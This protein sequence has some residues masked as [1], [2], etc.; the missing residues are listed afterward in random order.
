MTLSLTDQVFNLPEHNAESFSLIGSE[1]GKLL[2]VVDE[3]AFGTEEETMLNNMISAIKF[4][5]KSDISKLI[6]KQGQS[7][8]LSN[9]QRDFNNILV[10]GVIPE[11]LGLNIEYKLYDILHFEKCRMLICDSIIEIKTVIQKKQLLWSRLQEMFLK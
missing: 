7:I 6:L 3:S 2:V 1:E 9:L 11:Q 4:D 5:P 10:F 8:I